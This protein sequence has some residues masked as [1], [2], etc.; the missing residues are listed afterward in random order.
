MFG[1]TVVPESWHW[2]AI[3]CPSLAKNTIKLDC[4]VLFCSSHSQTLTAQMQL[5]LILGSSHLDMLPRQVSL[6]LEELGAALKKCLGT[7]SNSPSSHELTFSPE[8][9]EVLKDITFTSA[10]EPSNMTAACLL[11]RACLTKPDFDISLWWNGVFCVLKESETYL[12]LQAYGLRI[13]L[14][15]LIYC[16]NLKLI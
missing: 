4:L 10:G 7:V 8:P 2:P 12:K 1:Q 16:L 13:F 14:L 3:M 5:S 6:C 15:Q 11:P 9:A